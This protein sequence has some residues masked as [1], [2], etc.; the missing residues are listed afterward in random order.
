[1]ATAGWDGTEMLSGSRRWR[2]V[3]WRAIQGAETDN[4]YEALRYSMI[5][6]DFIETAASR[7]G[8]VSPR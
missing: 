4:K 2:A 5:T 8:Q 1:M 6:Q 3:T 7:S